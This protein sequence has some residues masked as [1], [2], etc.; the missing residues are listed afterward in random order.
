MSAWNL[1]EIVLSVGNVVE[2]CCGMIWLESNHLPTINPIALT[3]GANAMTKASHSPNLQ[4]DLE[5]IRVQ[6]ARLQFVRGAAFVENSSACAQVHHRDRDRMQWVHDPGRSG[7]YL[8][9]TRFGSVVVALLQFHFGICNANKS[10]HRPP[11][12]AKYCTRMFKAAEQ[13]WVCVY[14]SKIGELLPD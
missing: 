5:T 7:F 13:I 1:V 12:V 6:G 3:A 8:E 4:M 2:V 10:Q 9:V 11:H 14:Q